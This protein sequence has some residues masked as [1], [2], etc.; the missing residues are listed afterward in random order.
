M[1]DDDENILGKLL[2]DDLTDNKGIENAGSEINIEEDISGE[3]IDQN[4]ILNY[5]LLK[6]TNKELIKKL[7]IDYF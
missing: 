2:I 3:E 5:A 4:Y 1:S 7:E 6:G